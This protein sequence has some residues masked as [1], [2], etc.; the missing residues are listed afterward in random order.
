MI[1]LFGVAPMA[2]KSSA[3]PKSTA[4]DKHV[5]VHVHVKAEPKKKEK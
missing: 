1:S 2:K 3:R 4:R 5:H